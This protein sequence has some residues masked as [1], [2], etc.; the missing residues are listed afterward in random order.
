MQFMQLFA[1]LTMIMISLWSAINM[2]VPQPIK[3][4]TLH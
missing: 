2:Q 4:H 1:D 3:F